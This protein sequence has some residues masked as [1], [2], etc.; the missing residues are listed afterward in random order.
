MAEFPALPL[1]T[2]A[3]MADTRHLS[4]AQHGAYLL[5]LMTAWRMPDCKLPNDD[6]F[7]GRCASMDARTW[8]SNKDI[9]MGFWCQ[10]EMQKWCQR[11]LLDERKNVEDRR[12]K[13]SLAGKSSALKNKQRHSTS[14]I[15]KH[16]PKH[17]DTLNLNLN[18][19]QEERKNIKKKVSLD[20]LSIGHILPWLSEKQREGKYTNHKPD[21]ILEK[22][23][24]YCQANGKKYSDYV[25]AYR[26]A[27]D[28]ESCQ[29]PPNFTQTT[30][31][32]LAQPQNRMPSP[33][34]G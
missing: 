28:W 6:V 8:K 9:I 21:F 3:Y 32:W 31:E 11:R 2:D 22:F 24:N 23:K 15:T 16:P 29:P 13:N 33:A 27:F 34:G 5:L 1:F 4:A 7:L 20:D 14:V 10:D 25:A 30:S 26:N 19:N 12:N 18:L 17:N